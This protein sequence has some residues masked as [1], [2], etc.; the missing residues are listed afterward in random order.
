M[1]RGERAQPL[2]PERDGVGCR[3]CSPR[4]LARARLRAALKRAG[5]AR[6]YEARATSSASTRARGHSAA[7]WRRDSL[8]ARRRSAVVPPLRQAT[9]GSR[10]CGRRWPWGRGTLWLREPEGSPTGAP[11]VGGAVAALALART[12]LRLRQGRAELLGRHRRRR[13]EAYV[14]YSHGAGGGEARSPVSPGSGGGEAGS[15]A[16]HGSIGGECSEAGPDS[17]HGTGGGEA[18]IGLHGSSGGEAGLG[19]SHGS[20]GGE[21][22]STSGSATGPRRR[23]AARPCQ[24]DESTMAARVRRRAAESMASEAAASA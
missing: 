5:A 14:G 4:G 23:R 19:C 11:G 18:E 6:R 22:W 2:E 3:A 15:G 1:A 20:G 8:A 16:S 13:G 21:A 9:L 10:C 17:S 12:R 24:R 7:A